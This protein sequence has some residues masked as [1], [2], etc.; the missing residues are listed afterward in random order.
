MLQATFNIENFVAFAYSTVEDAPQGLGYSGPRIVLNWRTLENRSASSLLAIVAHEMLHVST[1]SASGPFV[2]TWA[3][4]GFADFVGYAGDPSSLS[5]LASKVTAGFSPSVLPKD[6]QFTTGSGEQIYT[7]Y[8]EAE[9]AVRFFVLRWGL[10]AWRRFYRSL[11]ARRIEWGTTRY[12]IDRS[13]R[14]AIGIGLRAFQQAW[15]S[16]LHA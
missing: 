2:P 9:S 8:Q 10:A 13:L 14:G 15:A 16:S 4:E 6:Y 12:Q 3:E 11:G 1:R 5:F 7:S